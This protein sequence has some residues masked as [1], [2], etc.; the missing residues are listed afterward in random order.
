MGPG[1]S[2]FRSGLRASN[3]RK[4]MQECFLTFSK[5]GLGTNLDQKICLLLPI[6]WLIG[7]QGPAVTPAAALWKGAP[8]GRSGP[9]KK[10]LDS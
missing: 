8:G 4:L 6:S 10:F 1:P 7:F 2:R 9:R 3:F 5:W